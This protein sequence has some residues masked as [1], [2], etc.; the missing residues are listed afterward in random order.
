MTTLFEDEWLIAVSKPAGWRSDEDL[1]PAVSEGIG[2]EAVLFHRLDK[3][4]SGV[5]LL[6]K[7]KE[8]NA[9]ISMAFEKHRIRKAYLAVVHG[10]WLPQWNRVESFVVRDSASGRMRNVAE[11]T[12]EAK[13]ALTTFRLLAR[14]ADRSLIEAMP[15]TGRTHQ[16]RL[17]CALQKRPVMGDKLYGP[18]GEAAMAQALHAYRL[19]FR[20]P[21]T[22]KDIRIAAAVPEAW[23]ETW[24]APLLANPDT[25]AVV[26]R[27]LR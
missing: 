5:I 14:A 20:H 9:G 27:Y 23:Q 2:R 12:P 21:V 22:D 1:R 16:I 17:H 6:G 10:E 24:L 25:R 11:D 18:S 4:T 15:K 26:E 19:D 3:D 8:A 7:R 13:R